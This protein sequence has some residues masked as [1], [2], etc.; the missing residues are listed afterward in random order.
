MSPGIYIEPMHRV[1]ESLW[2]ETFVRSYCT[3]KPTTSYHAVH[4]CI[5]GGALH[6]T[7]PLITYNLQTQS[8]HD[9]ERHLH[10]A[11]A[12]RV[13]LLRTEHLFGDTPNGQLDRVII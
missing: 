8:R 2:R 11:H 9:A 6:C 3:C 4:P 5:V 1:L 12:R 7:H 10:N 13:Q